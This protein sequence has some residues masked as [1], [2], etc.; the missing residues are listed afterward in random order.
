MVGSDDHD[1]LVV[2]SL[3]LQEGNEVSESRVD[4][5]EFRGILRIKA[6]ITA[7]WRPL[8]AKLKKGDGVDILRLYIEKEW[9]PSL[10]RI[11]GRLGFIHQRRH[12]ELR[13]VGDV[14][15]ERC[16]ALFGQ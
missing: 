10:I 3:R 13:P 16:H 2:D 8:L 12:I 9:F 11:D 14:L 7:L 1:A 5:L 15:P 4:P 6:G